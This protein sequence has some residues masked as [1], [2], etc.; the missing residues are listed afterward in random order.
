MNKNKKLATTF[1]I[2]G[3]DICFACDSDAIIPIGWYRVVITY[4]TNKKKYANS[5]LNFSY[6]V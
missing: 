2:D 3:I 4:D 1:F 5:V 6:Y